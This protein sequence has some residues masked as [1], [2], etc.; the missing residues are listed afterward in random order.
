M[1]IDLRNFRCFVA[2]AEELHFHRAAK[3]LGVAQP[4][5]SRTIRNLERD[6]GVVLFVRSNRSV[7]ITTAGQ[8]FLRGCKEV[9]NK[10]AQVVEDVQRVHEGKIGTLR[11]GYTDCAI[12]GRAPALLKEFQ[13]TH[14]DIELR[15]LHTVTSNQLVGLEDG[16]FDFGFATGSVARPGFEFHRI[17]REMFVCVVYE[18]HR[19][20][21]LPSV[22]IRNLAHEPMVQGAAKLWEHFH[23][24]LTPLYR[25]AGFEP[26]IT[27]EGLATSD[28]LRL[29][30]CGMGITV[31]TQSVK[32]TLPSGLVVI[33]LKGVSD[34]LDTVVVWKTEQNNSAKEHFV[35]YIK[36]AVTGNLNLS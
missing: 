26:H 15:L 27:Q 13:R 36:G 6:L 30:A 3:K 32:D 23:S 28:I 25:K 14:P 29:V 1:A 33:P 35:S 4:A 20:A 7:E 18:G 5:L 9:L 22:H 12:N 34:Q 2:V 24:Y 19:F 17:Q 11:I 31:L 8:T 21:N 16:I 10:T